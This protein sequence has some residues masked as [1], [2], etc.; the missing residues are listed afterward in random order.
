[1]AKSVVFARLIEEHGHLETEQEQGDEPLTGLS[2]CR[3]KKDANL[4][5]DT[6]PKKTN[7]AL[8]QIEERNTGAVTWDTYLKY[9]RFAGSATWAPFLLCLLTL[10]QASQGMF[11]R[12]FLGTRQLLILIQLAIICFLDFGRRAAYRDFHREIIWLFMLC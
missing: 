3:D 9:L 12:N 10:S 5:D 11:N 8:M 2:K 1:M 6:G 7:A 4:D